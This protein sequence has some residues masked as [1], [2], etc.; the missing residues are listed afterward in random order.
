[1]R[2]QNQGIDVWYIDESSDA[3]NFAMSAISV[4]ML[5]QIDGHWHIVWDDHLKAVQQLRR[6]LQ[7]THRIPVRKELHAVTLAAGRGRYRDG[8]SN[9]TQAAGCGV[10]RWIL[11]RLTFLQQASIISVVGSSQSNLYGHTKLEALMYAL[12]QRMQRAATATRRNGMVFFDNGHGEY[13]TLYRKAQVHLPTG[14]QY[15]AWD[16]GAH[17]KNIPMDLFFKDG[18]FKDS[19]HSLFIQVADLIAYAA[20]MKAR[21]QGNALRPWQ[22]RGGLGTAYDAI[23]AQVIN[24][25]ASARCPYGLG[26]VWL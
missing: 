5:R 20:L 3:N 2:L 19:A 8:I 22:Q 1:M 15:G 14:S 23:P 4:P 25:R 10:Y 12:F 13:R 7:K 16:S 21:V 11:S 9:F 6:D 26:L 24:K 17:S 18:N